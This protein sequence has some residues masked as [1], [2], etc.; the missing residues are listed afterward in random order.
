MR[1]LI[2]PS[3]TTAVSDL[4]RCVVGQL[5]WALWRWP[6]RVEATACLAMAWN[7]VSIGDI[8]SVLAGKATRR[9]VAILA[10]RL[11]GWMKAS[12]AIAPMCDMLCATM[13]FAMQ[14]S[15][16]GLALGL[17]SY[18]ALNKLEVSES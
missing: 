11:G 7:L 12:Q 5:A 14:C 15:L 9:E 1:G 10:I 4:M 18:Y 16:V 2:N 8:Q 6:T 13:Y 3:C 17:P